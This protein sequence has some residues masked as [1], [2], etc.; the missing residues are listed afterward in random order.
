[1]NIYIYDDKKQ[2]YQSVEARINAN[3]NDVM[4]DWY[5][6]ITGYGSSRDEAL[7]NLAIAVRVL[8]ERLQNVIPL[9]EV[10]S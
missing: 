5:T 1:M 6:D 10:Y 8:I 9:D 3:D 4:W 7:Q 2:K